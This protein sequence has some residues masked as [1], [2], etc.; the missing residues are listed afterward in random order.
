MPTRPRDDALIRPSLFGKLFRNVNRRAYLVFQSNIRRQLVKRGGYDPAKAREIG[1]IQY[2]PGRG[3]DD[4]GV[5]G[6]VIGAPMAALAAEF[7][8]ALGC[9]EIVAFGTCGSIHGRYRIGR[10]VVPSEAVSEDGTSPLYLPGRNR[11]RADPA[12]AASV[13]GA[14]EAAGMEPWDGA[15][16]TT[17]AIFR[18][19]PAKIER[20]RQEG[21]RVVEMEL[22]A[23]CA[24][25]E[26]REAKVAGL[27]LVSDE[28]FGKR[29]RPGFL[30]PSFKRSI[31]R[32]VDAL[33]T[34]R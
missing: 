32:G 2:I 25:G 1:A 7:L 20:F 29:W 4:F 24:V 18:E 5:A 15:T 8:I 27:L 12:L 13:R 11:F 3:R 14:A 9:R 34:L 17:D 21:C 33:L 23:L 19:T 22:A 30:F 6:P 26:F 10:A 28:L 31:R 16:W